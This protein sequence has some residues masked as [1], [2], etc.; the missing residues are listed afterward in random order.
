[1]NEKTRRRLGLIFVGLGLA[2]L[3]GYAI[4]EAT[5]YPWEMLFAKWGWVEEKTLETLPEPPALPE[6]LIQL[7]EKPAEQP[8]ETVPAPEGDEAELADEPILDA[9]QQ[10][11]YR[12]EVSL[13][14]L[15]SVKIPKISVSENLLA[16]TGDEMYY[17]LGHYTGTAL[18]G[19]EGNC[20][21]AGHRNL[22]VAHPFRHLD[23]LAEGDEIYVTYED[24]T[25]CYQVYETFVVAP[26]E[27]WV[28]YPQAGE[29]NMLT[30]VTCTPVVNA[31]NRLIIW[32]RLVS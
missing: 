17:G 21:I 32:A 20:V 2:I 9:P 5:A 14:I 11:L 12:P 19:Q 26:D 13:N 18:P 3:L 4:Y 31:V 16:G 27:S 29:T 15:G 6:K 7:P 25:Y 28:M 10:V 30:L 23:K 22:I 8:Q 24:V 1:M